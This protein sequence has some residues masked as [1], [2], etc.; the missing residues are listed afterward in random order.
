ME[1]ST[2]LAYYIV[3]ALA[4]YGILRMLV[5]VLAGIFRTARERSLTARGV[6]QTYPSIS[7]LV[8]VRNSGKTILRTLNSLQRSNYPAGQMQVL[9]MNYGSTDETADEVESVAKDPSSRF[10]ITMITRPEK[11]RVYANTELMMFLNAGCTVDANCIKNI[12]RRFQDPYV[13]AAAANVKVLNKGSFSPVALG[14]SLMSVL[15]G[16]YSDAVGSVF[17]RTA[18]GKKRTEIVPVTDAIVYTTAK[19]TFREFLNQRFAQK[20]TRTATVLQNTA[21]PHGIAVAAIT[22][23]EIIGILSILAAA[24]MLMRADTLPLAIVLSALVLVPVAG[25][26]SADY[27]NVWQKVRVTVVGIPALYLFLPALALAEYAG[28]LT[29]CTGTSGAKISSPKPETTSLKL[30]RA[31]WT[32]PVRTLS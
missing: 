25:I 14:Q 12:A 7:V 23:R 9:V 15:T 26:W 28:T 22:I 1:L 29:A 5:Q 20:R 11:G 8:P 18:F 24:V 27:L 21:I 10:K 2:I 13:R 3:V 31:T 30:G 17:R 6:I 32:S 16:R 19:P 4:G